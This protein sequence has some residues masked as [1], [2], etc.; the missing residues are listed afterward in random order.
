MKIRSLAAVAAAFTLTASPVLA[1][2]ADVT[3]SAT[4][5][6]NGSEMGGNIIFAL[7]AAVLI[8]GGIVI[9]ADNESDTPTSP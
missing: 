4:P 8:I 2:S 5:V 9:A 6:E 7:L 3:R 1:Q